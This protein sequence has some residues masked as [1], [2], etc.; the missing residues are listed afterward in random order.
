VVIC[1]NIPAARDF[2]I[3]NKTAIVLDDNSPENF[4]S[5][6]IYVL[7]NYNY[8]KNEFSKNAE[9]VVAQWDYEI[10]TRKLEEFL[11]SKI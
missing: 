10:V 7:E 9:E 5:N 4:R 6:I 3:H 1:N 8:F 11:I 2:A